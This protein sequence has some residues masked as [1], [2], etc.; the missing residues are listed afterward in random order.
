M[1]T[2][3][4]LPPCL[5]ETYRFLYPTIQWVRVRFFLDLPVGVNVLGQPAIT[6]SSGATPINVYIRRDSYDPCSE[7]TFLILAHELVH[8][9]Q[10]QDLPFAGIVPGT[11]TSK[12]I[13]CWLASGFKTQEGN[14]LEDEAYLHAN[15]YPA[16]PEAGQLRQCIEN[17]GTPT[18]IPELP[19]DCANL[20]WLSTNP[21]FG[22]Y[23]QA[24]C[25]N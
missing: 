21:G 23:I 14:C 20:P 22:T 4:Q 19:C 12:Y 16:N 25:P 13:T 24:Q 15:G 18:G 10:I 3:I 6:L 9:L 5:D 2:Q 11:W 17:P 7:G 8:V 1:P